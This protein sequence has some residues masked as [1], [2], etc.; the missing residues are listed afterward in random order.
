[1]SLDYD[2]AEV[3]VPISA[4]PADPGMLEGATLEPFAISVPNTLWIHG[5]FG[6]TPPDVAAL[7]AERA[8]GSAGIVNFRVTHAGNV[9]H[10]LLTH[11]SLSLIRMK[12]VTVTGELV[13]R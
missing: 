5:L 4:K 1:M 7:V 12:R 10:W 13:R 11:L 8:E 3:P 6:H 2:L 9:H